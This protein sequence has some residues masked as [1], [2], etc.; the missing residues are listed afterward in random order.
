MVFRER[1]LMLSIH[2]LDASW[3][4]CHNNDKDLLAFINSSMCAVRVG[5]SRN[6]RISGDFNSSHPE[7]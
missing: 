5:D 1:A 2:F 6:F 3:S 4:D 7:G